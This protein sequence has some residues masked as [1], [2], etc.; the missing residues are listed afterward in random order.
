MQTMRMLANKIAFTMGLIFA[1]FV[2]SAQNSET[3]PAS[4]NNGTG[5][6]LVAIIV[7]FITM[8]LLHLTFRLIYRYSVGKQIR[9]NES[10]ATPE[11]KAVVHE[12]ISGE[13]FAAISTALH[14]YETEQ[15]D[16]ESTILTIHRATKSY[17]PWSSKIYGL[18]QVP[19]K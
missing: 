11:G 7:V 8:I 12:E 9:N 18:R 4:Q 2:V 17:S 6:F 1:G 10:N 15:H 19:R 3:L 16:F 14:L 13:V 5:F